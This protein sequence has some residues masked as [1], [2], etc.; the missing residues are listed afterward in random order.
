[1][2]QHVEDFSEWILC[3]AHK[4]NIRER[5]QALED[6]KSITIELQ[7]K[8]ISIVETDAL[9]KSVIDSYAD[10]NFERYLGKDD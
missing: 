8:A 1:M 3:G 4:R 10:F 7:R 6:L 9:F 2:D 5:K